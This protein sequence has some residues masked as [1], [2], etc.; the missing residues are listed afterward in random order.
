[1]AADERRA[2]VSERDAEVITE[3]DRC[4]NYAVAC[5]LWETSRADWY[6]HV[7]SMTAR[8]DAIRPLGAWR[9]DHPPTETMTTIVERI[10]AQDRSDTPYD[11][12]L[13][14]VSALERAGYVSR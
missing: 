8:P 4:Y 6:S 3:S 1:M 14:I 12:A 10:I 2:A 13:Q 7:A 9:K 11:M 5:G